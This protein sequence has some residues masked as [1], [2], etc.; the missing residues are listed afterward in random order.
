[1]LTSL[2][3]QFARRIISSCQRTTGVPALSKDVKLHVLHAKETFIRGGLVFTV[4]THHLWGYIG[5][6]YHL[7]GL[8]V[9]AAFCAPAR[10]AV[11][12]EGVYVLPV[13]E[14][15]GGADQWY[16]VLRFLPSG[17]LEELKGDTELL[18]YAQLSV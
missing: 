6:S 2:K 5:P 10:V 17:L 3:R 9:R 16:E 8:R 1:M 18:G 15:A 12:P 4:I 14:A 7:A 13:R 11:P